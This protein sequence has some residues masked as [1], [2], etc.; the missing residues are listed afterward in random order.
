MIYLYIL[1]NSVCKSAYPKIQGQEEKYK[2]VT[3]KYHN[4]SQHAQ[5]NL[6]YIYINVLI[7][8]I[9]TEYTYMLIWIFV[10]FGLA[11]LE[12]TIMLQLVKQR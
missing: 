1:I 2:H 3:G 12:R 8:R 10:W 6:D 9:S 11:F 5:V 4:F 7:S